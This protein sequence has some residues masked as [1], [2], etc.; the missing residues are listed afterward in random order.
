MIG[1]GEVPQKGIEQDRSRRVPVG[2]DRHSKG[3][4]GEERDV[5]LEMSRCPYIGG[6]TGGRRQRR[7]GRC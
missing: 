4:E 6:R 5:D 1:S 2:A 3:G 7:Q